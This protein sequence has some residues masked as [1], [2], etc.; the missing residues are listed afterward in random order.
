MSNDRL[1]DMLERYGE[2]CTQKDAAK[3]LSVQPRSIFRMLEQ[4][5]LR[6][7]GHRVDVRSIAEFLDNLTDNR[8]GN[9][10]SNGGSN[11]G[12]NCGGNG[13]SNS[14]SLITL[15]RRQRGI[16]LRGDSLRGASQCGTSMR[17]QIEEGS[18]FAA[19]KNR[20]RLA[21]QG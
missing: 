19:A 21:G 14:S 17:S 5:R 10:G 4:G 11:G 18:F 15:T 20:R 6:R 3:I 12:R 7:I 2:V 13:G 16:S 8:V 9:G 1:N